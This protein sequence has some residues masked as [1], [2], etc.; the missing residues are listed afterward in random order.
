MSQIRISIKY[1]CD[2]EIIANLAVSAFSSYRTI[3]SLQDISP[4][5]NEEHLNEI[6]RKRGGVKYTSWQFEGTPLEKGDAFLSEVYKIVVK[7]V[8]DKK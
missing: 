7:G 5:L 6:I 4:N 1:N 2:K 3:M 8:D